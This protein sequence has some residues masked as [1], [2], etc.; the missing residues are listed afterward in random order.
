MII[1]IIWIHFISDFIL[2][3]RFLAQNKYNKIHILCLHSSIYTIPFIFL[4]YKY[5][6]VNGLLH[7]IIDFISSKIAHYFWS[8]EKTYYFF[9]TIG[10]DQAIHLTCL[11]LTLQLL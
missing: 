7:L 6:I 2:Q 11:I 9:A 10:I 4:G 1:I 8:K 5:A 3:N